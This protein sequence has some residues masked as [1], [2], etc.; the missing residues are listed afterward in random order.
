[1]EQVH[2]ASLKDRFKNAYNAFLCK[3]IKQLHVGVQITR[4]EECV[5]GR[6]E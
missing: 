2:K 5:H 3:P 6:K 4:C 1:M